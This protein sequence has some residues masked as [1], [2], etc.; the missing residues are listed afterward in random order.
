LTP[1]ATATTTPSPTPTGTPGCTPPF[2]YLQTN[3]DGTLA[4]G[5]VKADGSVTASLMVTNIEPSATLT[6]SSKIQTG[7]AKD[8]SVVGGSCTT[9]KK[10]AA[11]DTC[12]Y[13][14]KLKGNK[15]DQG[16]A[17]NS[18]LVIT[19]MFGPGVCP[20]GDMQTVTVTL[21]GFVEAKGN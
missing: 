12:N 4:F 17:V 14:L 13:K 9:H 7:D 10:L 2:G 1:T 15:S 16:T 21:A 6:L 11:G 19:G 3:P 8:F 18:N 5:D 20:M